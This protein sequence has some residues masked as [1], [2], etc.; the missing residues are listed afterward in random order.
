MHCTERRIFGQSEVD[1]DQRG[2]C[3]QVMGSKVARLNAKPQVMD[4]RNGVKGTRGS[5]DPSITSAYPLAEV[6]PSNGVPL[7][8][9]VY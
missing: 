6:A 7:T 9:V 5:T 1:R 2:R 8:L 3:D 4:S